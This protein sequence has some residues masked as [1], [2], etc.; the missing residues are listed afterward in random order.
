MLTV[1]YDH[2]KS[3]RFSVAIEQIIQHI[4]SG[5]KNHSS[6]ALFLCLNCG[7]WTGQN[8]AHY[9]FKYSVSSIVL[10]Y[11]SSYKCL[12][13]DL[14]GSQGRSAHLEP[15]T[16][17]DFQFDVPALPCPSLACSSSAPGHRRL[18]SCTPL[19][20]IAINHG[21]HLLLLFIHD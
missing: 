20:V 19:S 8:K 6:D 3:Y 4:N 12:V 5:H 17:P 1:L 18:L 9:K 11:R 14:G 10:S 21:L 13:K 7:V 16:A 15:G 2:A